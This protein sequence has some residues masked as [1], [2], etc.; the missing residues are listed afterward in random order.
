MIE[1]APEK[2]GLPRP[3]PKYFWI[4]TLQWTDEMGRLRSRTADGMMTQEGIDASRS[5]I[6]QQVLAAVARAFEAENS[7]VLF[8]SLEPEYL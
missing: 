2:L 1:N 7:S 4:L 3:A 8:F 6:Y 5:A